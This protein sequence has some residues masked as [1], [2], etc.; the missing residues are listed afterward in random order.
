MNLESKFQGEIDE[1]TRKHDNLMNQKEGEMQ[2]LEGEL[3][4][5]HDFKDT[6]QIREENLS[7]EMKRFKQL[8]RQLENLKQEGQA[9]MESMKR[10][11]DERNEK[12]LKDFERTAQSDA[13]KNISEIERNIQAQNQRLDDEAKLQQ[14]ELEYMQQKTENYSDFNNDLESQ[15]QQ[16]LKM[17]QEIALRQYRQNAKI[18]ELKTKIDLLESSLAQIVQ[19]FE[20]EREL[21]KFQNEQIIKEQNDELK[22]LTESNKL[23]IKETSNLKALCQ[24]ILDQ[25]SDIEQFFLEAQEQVKEEKRRKLENER[26]AQIAQTQSQNF[27]KKGLINYIQQ[28]KL[29]EEQEAKITVEL[30]DLDWEDRERI[31][32]LLFS[33]MN[34]GQSAADWRERPDTSSQNRGGSSHMATAQMNQSFRE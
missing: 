9:E 7:R 1:M 23:K 25:R 13:E 12:K 27:Q 30:A 22:S 19:D 33:K 26:K 31:L 14:Y 28:D 3:G 34:T 29:S 17:N 10:K 32:R 20:K 21:I 5:L 15:L 18:K 6:K 16:K 11:I 4:T 24:M 8:K 2:N